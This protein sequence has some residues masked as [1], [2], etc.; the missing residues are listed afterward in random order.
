LVASLW[1]EPSPAADHLDRR[2]LDRASPWIARVRIVGRKIRRLIDDGTIGDGR[3]AA[4]LS[5]VAGSRLTGSARK[6]GHY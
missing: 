2:L 3:V 5:D 1:R 6:L 4:L